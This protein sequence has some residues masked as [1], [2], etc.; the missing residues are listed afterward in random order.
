[1][2]RPALAPAPE[3][4]RRGATSSRQAR[5]SVTF[6]AGNGPAFGAADMIDGEESLP[7]ESVARVWSGCR[8]GDHRDGADRTRRCIL[9]DQG[10][11]EEASR[12]DDGAGACELDRGGG[13]R[14]LRGRVKAAAAGSLGF[15]D[16]NGRQV[17]LERGGGAAALGLA[18][19]QLAQ[20]RTSG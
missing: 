7:S 2:P 4:T 6:D 18:A 20:G 10:V 3:P 11:G 19:M 8:S 13:E 12:A 5:L 15:V 16:A 14:L 9:V 17:G 1:M